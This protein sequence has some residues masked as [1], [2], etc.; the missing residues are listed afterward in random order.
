M[1]EVELL[2][3]I[4][5]TLGLTKIKFYQY[6]WNIED[7]YENLHDIIVRNDKHITT[8]MDECAGLVKKYGETPISTL[9]EF[10]EYSW[11]KEYPY[12]VKLS[13]T[14]LIDDLL[15]DLNVIA[16][17]F[18][19]YLEEFKD[20]DEIVELLT[21]VLEGTRINITRINELK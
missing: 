17:K 15:T 1:M 16:N 12:H 8:Y 14:E 5:G 4:I 7:K 3:E 2:N 21:R 11:I 13:S 10:L 20:N 18:E 9:T 19:E 6:H